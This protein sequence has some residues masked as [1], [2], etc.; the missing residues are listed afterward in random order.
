M[1]TVQR[2]ISDF[3]FS[4]ITRT[5]FVFIH[6]HSIRTSAVAI[7]AP[8][9]PGD[10]CTNCQAGRS[11][12]SRSRHT[13]ISAISTIIEVISRKCGR[14][15]G[16]QR[17]RWRTGGEEEWVAEMVEV[18]LQC[19]SPCHSSGKP[20]KSKMRARCRKTRVSGSPQNRRTDTGASTTGGPEWAR[21]PGPKGVL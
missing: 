8:I 15:A 20:G 17:C 7:A 9:L 11:E 12:A 19:R 10:W 16:G 6:M 1:P 18:A 4:A 3:R 13:L 14:V 5:G 21:G 2:E